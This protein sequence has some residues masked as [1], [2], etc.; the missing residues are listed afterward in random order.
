MKAAQKKIDDRKKRNKGFQTLGTLFDNYQVRQTSK[1]VS[2][3][4][5]DGV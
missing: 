1:Y 3:E 4:F 5:Q 2:R